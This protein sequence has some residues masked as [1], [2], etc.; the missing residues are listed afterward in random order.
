MG[1]CVYEKRVHIDVSKPAC[2]W[3]AKVL[4]G[5]SERCV[6]VGVCRSACVPAHLCLCRGTL[7]RCEL[8]FRFWCAEASWELFLPPG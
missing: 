6:C 8:A 2:V 5:V 3:V 4:V 7:R 1:V